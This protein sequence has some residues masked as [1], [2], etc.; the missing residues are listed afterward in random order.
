MAPRFARLDESWAKDFYW[1]IL[2]KYPSFLMI[3]E[4]ISSIYLT[5]VLKDNV[6]LFSF[7]FNLT[8]MPWICPPAFAPVAPGEDRADLVS[9]LSTKPSPLLQGIDFTFPGCEFRSLGRGWGGFAWQGSW[10]RRRHSGETIPPQMQIGYH[11]TLKLFNFSGQQTH[12]GKSYQAKTE[13]WSFRDYPVGYFT[14]LFPWKVRKQ[15]LIWYINVCP[16]SSF[17]LL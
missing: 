2:M 17:M 16:E 1:H 13:A 7:C 14:L 15:K 6:K 9:T 8:T 10:R 4:V 11:F 3:L 12:P 5:V